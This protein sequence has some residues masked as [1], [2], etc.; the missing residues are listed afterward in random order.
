MFRRSLPHH[1]AAEPPRPRSKIIQ[2]VRL[3]QHF[4]VM[5]DQDQRV[6]EILQLMQRFQQP[7][8]VAR[9]ESDGRLIQY[10]Q[11]A[12]QGAADLSG[13]SYPLALTPRQRGER[14]GQREVLQSDIHQERQ[15][16]DHLLQQVTGDPLVGR[17]ELQPLEERVTLTQ[18]QFA[19]FLQR[20]AV[21][22][23]R[24][25]IIPQPAAVTG[26]AG[27][28]T[29]QIGQPLAI[30]ERHAGRLFQRGIQSLV[31]E[32]DLAVGGQR[33][34]LFARAVEDD[35]LLHRRQLGERGVE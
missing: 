3:G 35:P 2:P 22:P 27:N 30:D 14:P 7:G 5:F 8:V 17:L 6:A 26:R 32:F 25:G 18:R 4:P 15:P 16:A 23:D 10:I 29:L 24:P 28:L 11:H 13:E 31:L 9:M 1:V 19:Q 21:E 20:A 12:G 33:D 34:P